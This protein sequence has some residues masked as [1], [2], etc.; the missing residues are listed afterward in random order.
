LASKSFS[1]GTLP[2]LTSPQ[3]ANTCNP[4]LMERD[5]M[6]SLEEREIP[7]A[8]CLIRFL[9]SFLVAMSIP[10]ICVPAE[11]RQTSEIKIKPIWLT[12]M[13]QQTPTVYRIPLEQNI[14]AEVRVLK[15][16][17]I[18]SPRYGL[19]LCWASIP[20]RHVSMHVREIR[21]TGSIRHYYPEIIEKFDVAVVNGGFFSIDS[22]DNAY[23][24]G[25]VISEGR[26]VSKFVRSNVG[27]I[28][29]ESGGA[30]SIVPIKSFALNG[31]IGQAVQSKPILVSGGRKGVYSDDGVLFNRTAV[32]FD[33]DNFII[34]GGFQ[35]DLKALTLYEFAG[36]LTTTRQEGGPG[37]ESALNMDGAAG[38]NIVFPTLKL[39]FGSEVEIY[40]P[41]AI[42]FSRR[43]IP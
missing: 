4:Y 32:G 1:R 43:N 27:G 2:K 37:L 14:A 17:D 31:S 7:L 25:L 24:V 5:K 38:A 16:S 6:L 42:H 18:N 23:P 8:R 10:N 39:H 3:D 33:S 34:A 13:L 15:D 20:K 12:R 26:Q 40:L 28:L 29:L 35:E 21:R 41:N 11:T 9:L 30:V 22:G 19:T 36:F